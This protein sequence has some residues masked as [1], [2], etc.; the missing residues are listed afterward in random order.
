MH[1]GNAE[2]FVLSPSPATGDDDHGRIHEATLSPMSSTCTST[3]SGTTALPPHRRSPGSAVIAHGQVGTRHTLQESPQVHRR[4]V[5]PHTP[6][7]AIV[8]AAP[9][10]LI[11][12]PQQQ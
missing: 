3:N 4:N 2:L 12:P 1:S 5:L 7:T 6:A 11:V 8:T 9:E 10:A